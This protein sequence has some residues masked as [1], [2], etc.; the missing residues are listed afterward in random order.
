MAVGD[1]H[2]ASPISVE[3]LFDVFE[4]SMA[5]CVKAVSAADQAPLT[6]SGIGEGLTDQLPHPHV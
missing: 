6:A 4:L 1:A 3:N 5:A 2:S